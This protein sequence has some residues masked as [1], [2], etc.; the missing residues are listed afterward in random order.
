M[1]PSIAMDSHYARL[2]TSSGDRVVDEFISV[3]VGNDLRVAEF[4][5]ES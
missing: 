2:G 5:T 1:D 4:R 3:R